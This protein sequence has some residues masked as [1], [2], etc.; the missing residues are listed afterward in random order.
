MLSY[1]SAARPKDEAPPICPY[2]RQT[3]DDVRYGVRF[4]PMQ[5]RVVDELAKSS[6]M[7]ARQLAGVIYGDTDKWYKI[8]SHIHDIRAKL[9]NTTWQIGRPMGMKWGSYVIGKRGVNGTPAGGGTYR[10]RG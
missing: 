4:T 7:T 3:M 1:R 8:R 5:V 9:A 10:R 6:G 2:C